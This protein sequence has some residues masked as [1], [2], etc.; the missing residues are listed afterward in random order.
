MSVVS[1]GDTT[2]VI[3]PDAVIRDGKAA[4]RAA[5]SPQGE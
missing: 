4:G 3:M 1:G 5:C 2:N